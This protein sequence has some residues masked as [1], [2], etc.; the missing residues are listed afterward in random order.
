MN[1]HENEDILLDGIKYIRAVSKMI[2]LHVTGVIQVYEIEK[3]LY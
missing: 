1:S 2:Y 3:Y